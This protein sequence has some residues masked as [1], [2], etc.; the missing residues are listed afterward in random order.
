[1]VLI[2]R[3]RG[4]TPAS[5]CTQLTRLPGVFHN[6]FAAAAVWCIGQAWCFKDY[7]RASKKHG[8][9][10]TGKLLTYSANPI[11]KIFPLIYP[12]SLYLTTK[13][14]ST[15]EKSIDKFFDMGVSWRIAQC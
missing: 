14:L 7:S 13:Q 5:T 11:Y 12:R 10:E 15:F 3:R 8:C 9:T 6:F 4:K 2:A 1:M